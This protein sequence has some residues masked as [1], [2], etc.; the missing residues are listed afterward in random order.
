MAGRA[1]VGR[2]RGG[3]GGFVVKKCESG[4]ERRGG[5]KRED[6]DKLNG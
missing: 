1:S 2:V 6:G 5:K 4:D 3:V